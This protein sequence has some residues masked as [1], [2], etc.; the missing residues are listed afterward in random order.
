MASHKFDPVFNVNWRAMFCV[1]A[2]DVLLA[3]DALLARNVLL[4]RD[5]AFWCAMACFGARYLAKGAPLA[6][7]FC[8]VRLC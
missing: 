8:C 5:G 4:A 2:R 3:R 7:D 6:R 1:L